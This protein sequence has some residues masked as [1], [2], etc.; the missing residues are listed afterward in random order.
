MELL[1]KLMRMGQELLTLMVKIFIFNTFNFK[2]TFLRVHGDDVWIRTILLKFGNMLQTTCNEFDQY[3][4]AKIKKMFDLR[5]TNLKL[6]DIFTT[7]L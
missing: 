2:F 7:L 6:N 5:L 4:F 3:I 1:K